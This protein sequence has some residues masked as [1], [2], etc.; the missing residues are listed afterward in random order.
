MLTNL[1]TITW[2]ESTLYM[3]IQFQGVVSFTR[4][5]EV[6]SHE[7]NGIVAKAIHSGSGRLS[8]DEVFV[9][10]KFRICGGRFAGSRDD[11]DAATHIDDAQSCAEEEEYQA[12]QYRSALA[13][14]TMS[15]TSEWMI[16]TAITKYNSNSNSSTMKRSCLDGSVGNDRQ[17]SLR[18]DM[19]HTPTLTRPLAFFG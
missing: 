14:D 5:P 4:A 17:V 6:S 16:G 7:M 15:V 18:K 12:S 1:E 10:V 2:N 11:D 3:T 8:L 19:L 13:S 9:D